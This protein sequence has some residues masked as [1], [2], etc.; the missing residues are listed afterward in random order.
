MHWC[1]EDL[2]WALRWRLGTRIVVRSYSGY[3]PS[4]WRLCRL[5]PELRSKAID[6]LL[7]LY[8]LGIVR[9][10]GEVVGLREDRLRHANQ[11]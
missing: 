5:S 1:A 7:I 6:M 10:E 3:R 11:D 4:R 9:S 8:G 2:G